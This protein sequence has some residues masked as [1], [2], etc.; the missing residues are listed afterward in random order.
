MKIENL[1]FFEFFQ[2]FGKNFF[3]I[4]HVLHWFFK[5][6]KKSK[7]KCQIFEN[8]KKFFFRFISDLP[9][10][11]K[12][13]K[14]STGT[15]LWIKFRTLGCTNGGSQGFWHFFDPKISSFLGVN[16]FDVLFT[17]HVNLKIEIRKKNSKIFRKFWKSRFF[18]FFTYFPLVW[19]KFCQKLK[20]VEKKMSNFRKFEKIFFS[21]Y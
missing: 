3:T 5:N 8:L 17:K 12:F 9:C 7:K 14:K 4:F 21:I 18:D 2:K 20:K 1:R 19:S 10:I 13:R 11:A 15:P 16:F 6:L